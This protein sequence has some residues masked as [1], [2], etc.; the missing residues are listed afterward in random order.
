MRIVER[1]AVNSRESAK[2]GGSAAKQM[3]PDV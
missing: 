3:L 2:Y 1:Q